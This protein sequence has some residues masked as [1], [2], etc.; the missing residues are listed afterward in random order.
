MTPYM[1]RTKL[2]I[3]LFVCTALGAL[4][5]SGCDEL[6]T[7]V[8]QI[9]IAGNPTA[10]FTITPDSGCLSDT[11][12]V[13]RFRDA[14]SGPVVRWVWRFG[15]GTVDSTSGGEV[16]HTYDT[17]GVYSCTLWV[18]DSIGGSDSEG[19]QWG[20]VVDQAK[21]AFEASTTGGCAPMTVKFRTLGYRGITDWYWEFGNGDTSLASNPT[22][23]FTDTGT[24]TVTMIVSSYL[25]GT[26][27]TLIATDLIQVLAEAEADFSISQTEGCVG[28][29]VEFTNTSTNA[30][31]GLL[32]DFGDST[33]V[34]IDTDPVHVY[35]KAGSFTVTLIATCGDNADT[36][37]ATDAIVIDSAA[38][39]SI[40]NLPDQA[41]VDSTVGFTDASAGTNLSS[42]WRFVRLPD[43]AYVIDTTLPIDIEFVFPDTG[44][45]ELRLTAENSCNI[46]TVTDTIEIV[47]SP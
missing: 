39:A 6:V 41:F 38:V 19:K 9:T 11:G 35:N 7:E 8:Q 1:T 24:Y 31:D 3:A 15:D 21:A 25:C 29:T 46:N 43:S 17:G 20:V 37:I 27:D 34:S 36:L 5:W 45:W 13:V 32:W 30:E 22:Y 44:N 16:Y 18:Y 40:E 4:I 33:N 47:P 42:S 14:S 23:T 2:L 10:E 28:D 26:A 12:F